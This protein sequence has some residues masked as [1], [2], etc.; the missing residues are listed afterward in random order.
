MWEVSPK[1]I[2]KKG[3]S[4]ALTACHL[5][6][7]ANSLHFLSPKCYTLTFTICL[8]SSPGLANK[9][10]QEFP[11]CP[12][13]S[14]RQTF[15]AYCYA[16]FIRVL[17]DTLGLADLI[18]LWTGLIS[19]AAPGTLGKIRACQRPDGPERSTSEFSLAH[20]I[21]KACVYGLTL[22]PHTQVKDPG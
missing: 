1:A 12:L 21:Q 6:I 20:T 5:Y 18:P 9:A 15:T 22:P 2:R 4:R 14:F 10:Q 13:L 7:G 19:G 11:R 16:T 3:M 17:L 8:S